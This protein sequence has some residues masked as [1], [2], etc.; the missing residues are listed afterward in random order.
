MLP[1]GNTQLPHPDDSNNSSDSSDFEDASSEA[2]DETLLSK[3]LNREVI[4]KMNS[5]KSCSQSKI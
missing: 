5:D 3:C 2:I 1:L 4:D